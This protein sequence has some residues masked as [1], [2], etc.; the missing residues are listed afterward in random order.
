LLEPV[1]VPLEGRNL[2]KFQDELFLAFFL[3]FFV[4]THVRLVHL[5]SDN[6]RPRDGVLDSV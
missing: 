3:F 2:E 6:T 4:F 1:Q 5:I